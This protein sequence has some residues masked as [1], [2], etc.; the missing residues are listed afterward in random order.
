M[1]QLEF[2][3]VKYVSA[4]LETFF[5]SKLADQ[6]ATFPFGC[7]RTSPNADIVTGRGK[8]KKSCCAVYQR[9]QHISCPSILSSVAESPF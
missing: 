4:A 9:H 2:S 1:V 3:Q 8:H 6:L 5:G 7:Q